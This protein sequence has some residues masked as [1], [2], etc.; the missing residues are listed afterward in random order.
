MSNARTHGR[1]ALVGRRLEHNDHLG[2]GYL[3]AALATS[4]VSC[5]AHVLNRIEDVMPIARAVC[6]EQP[7][8]VGISLQDGGSA[9]L[10][11]ALGELLRRRGFR[12]HITAGGPFATLARAWL[13]D[14]YAWL[15]SVIRFAGEA[16][17]LELVRALREGGSFA[18][19]AGVST[20]AGDGSP[21]DVLNRLPVQLVPARHNAMRIL[22]HK[23][24]HLS[25]A[26]GCAGRCAYCGPAALQ[27]GEIEEGLRAG[28]SRQALAAAGVG[29]IRRRSVADVAAELAELARAG[30]RYLYFVDE[31]LLPYREPEALAWLAELGHRLAAA[32]T[33]R[34]ATGC[35]LRA[36]R[37]TGDIVG[38]LA[39]LGLARCYVGLELPS[40][41]QGRLFQRRCRPEH[42]LSI[43]REL[44]ARGVATIS[45]LM[46]V[47]PY[48]TV[49]SIAEG[50]G[51]LE[52][53][54]HGLVEVTHMKPY[55]GTALWRRLGEEG[56]LLGNP[57]RWDYVLADPAA[58]RFAELSLQI[59]MQVFGDHS[60][61]Q[62]LHELHTELAVARRLEMML[63]SGD[64]VRTL[65]DL[66]RRLHRSGVAA[67]RRALAVA[68]SSPS[69]QQTDD[70][71]GTLVHEANLFNAEL[72]QLEAE[73][74]RGLR[75]ADR[76]YSPVVAVAASSLFFLF[77]SASPG[78][79]SKSPT[80][81]QDASVHLNLDAPAE[82]V[83]A[84]PPSCSAE[85]SQS[86]IDRVAA[87]VPCF[88]GR[89]SADTTSFSLNAGGNGPCTLRP[90][91]DGTAARL[92][93]LKDAA[94]S[95]L[96]GL[97]TNGCYL[98]AEVVSQDNRKLA[99]AIG[100]ATRCDYPGYAVILDDHGAVVDVRSSNDAGTDT[101]VLDSILAALGGLTFPCLANAQICQEPIVMDF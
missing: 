12:G 93:Q 35:L 23:T 54:E 83:I 30:Y 73:L 40:A 8:V 34:F 6:S 67:L 76:R 28:H 29:S 87:A 14:R 39:E 62:R 52:R 36:E 98:M 22:G 18:A 63:P 81:G 77:A 71:L 89:V 37:L 80:P 96:Q 97:D 7:T 42:V 61:V 48:S 58:Q 31:H 15:D 41:E 17:L 75:V 59:R 51:F 85:I 26:R 66:R 92:A 72:V 100:S 56:R 90:C 13:L 49:A 24:A 64:M 65:A 11:L 19:I 55:H 1:V 25:A 16:P 46:L 45:N 43:L 10:L 82:L 50:L 78:C 20:R 27:E 47:H 57:L 79:S 74:H 84:L 94:S 32:H 5:R 38:K 99:N 68:R 4:G 53:V 88:S 70:L 44:D 33:P 69:R 86:A 101:E 60:L 2:I 95:A 3:E 9:V 91:D 21:A